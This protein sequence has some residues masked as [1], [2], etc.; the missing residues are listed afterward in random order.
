[1]AIC[2]LT[3][4]LLD[5]VEVRFFKLANKHMLSKLYFVGAGTNLEGDNCPKFGNGEYN[6]CYASFM[7][8]HITPCATG[9]FEV[10]F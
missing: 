8:L 6:S 5:L 3:S 10:F 9:Y 4:F 1:M 2:G 7:G